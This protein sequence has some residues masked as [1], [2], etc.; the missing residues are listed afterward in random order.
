MVRR[1]HLDTLFG[2][3]LLEL[4]KPHEKDLY[5]EFS[6]IERQVYEIVKVRMINRINSISKQEGAQGLQKKSSHIW[7]MILRLRQVTLSVL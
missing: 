4:P 6:E 7:T 1:T 2:A 5:L 3:K